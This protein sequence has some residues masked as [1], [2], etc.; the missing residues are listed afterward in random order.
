MEKQKLPGASAALV[1]GICSI[2]T[3]C[4]CYGL[5]GIILGIIGLNSAKKAKV[6]YEANPEQ[7]DG[8]S[9][10]NAGRITS[11]IGIVIGALYIVYLVFLLATIGF[12]GILEQNEQLM[13]Q[14][15]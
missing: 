10:A 1:L 2:V 15:Q 6:A 8:M 5:I 12:A 4:C 11:I 3:A 14:F 9:N 13:E 7:Y